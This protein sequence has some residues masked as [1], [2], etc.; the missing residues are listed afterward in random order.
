MGLLD[1]F[2]LSSLVKNKK[3]CELFSKEWS[4]FWARSKLSSDIRFAKALFAML[5]IAL[6]D[7]LSV[8]S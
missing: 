4:E 1:I 7:K 5:D 2:K 6:C 8:L 3:I